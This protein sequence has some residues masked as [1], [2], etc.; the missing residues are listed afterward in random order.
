M[1]C[2]AIL[3]LV[4]FGA[5]RFADP[6]RRGRAE[7]AGW[8]LLQAQLVE[9]ARLDRDSAR[10][11]LL[12]IYH[13]GLDGFQP[14]S[15]RLRPFPDFSPQRHGGLLDVGSNQ[16]VRE[17][18]GVIGRS[19]V[20]GWVV[21]VSEERARIVFADDP[22][23][24]ATFRIEGKG[25]GIVAGGPKRDTLHPVVH[26]DPFRFEEGDLLLTSGED[27]CF[28]RSL[29]LGVVRVASIPIETTRVE[30]PPGTTDPQEVLILSL[31][32]LGAG[33]RP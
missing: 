20:I 15:A 26:F 19:G 1:M 14:I 33:G 2:W 6:A 4:T 3:I 16:G 8:D 13:D 17:K 10:M 29:V 28:P 27:A 18:Q 32:T 21:E 11:S 30:L 12:E 22:N 25:R 5:K 7:K 31:P 24:R 9:S 23:F